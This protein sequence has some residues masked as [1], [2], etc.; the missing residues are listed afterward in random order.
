MERSYR[1]LLKHSGVYGLGHILTRLA[2]V[3]LLPV[4]TRFLAPADY[5]VLA[6]LDLSVALLAIVL[7]SG[8]VRSAVRHH[9]E[10][11]GERE[12]DALWW[13]GLTLLVLSG[14]VLLVP[15]LIFRESLAAWTLGGEQG[16][17]AYFFLLAL[18][19]LALSTLEQLFQAHLRVYKQSSLFVAV[20]LG[21]LLVNIALN[22]WLLIALRLGVAAILLGNLITAA[23]AAAVLFALFA[24]KRGRARLR[25]DLTGELFSYGTPLVV[26]SLL[27]TAMHSLDRYLL[28]VMLD[29]EEVGVYSVAYAI[30]QGINTLVLHPFSQIWYVVIYELDG[31]EQLHAAVRAVFRYF[32]TLLALLMLGI[33][34][35]AVPLLR[36]LVAPEFQ[37]AAEL[38]PILCLAYLFFSLHA[39]FNLPPLL[40]KRTM[41]TIPPHLL[42]VVVNVAANLALIPALG[43]RGAAWASVVTFAVYSFGGLVAYRRIRR[44]DYPLLGGGLALLGMVATFVAWSYATSWADGPI[45]AAGLAVIVWLGWAVVLL[46]PLLGWWGSARPKLPF[47]EATG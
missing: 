32:F 30:G 4:Y 40:A 16:R 34:L 11:G 41:A 25:F 2:S 23:I 15:A 22:L 21:R 31:K 36:L 46:A 28:R 12:R 14:V 6:I 27:A 39:H 47:F 8:T 26:A 42:G 24:R 19:T 3:L 7:A 20:S 44:F 17:G 9:F 13:T 37:P 33:S 5:G 43:A 38:I 18:S 45:V 29:L 35:F 1:D 10:A